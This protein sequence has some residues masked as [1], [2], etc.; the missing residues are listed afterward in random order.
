MQG[1]SAG[2]GCATSG[3]GVKASGNTWG[4][5]DVLTMEVTVRR[6]R[7]LARYRGEWSPPE[8]NILRR[9]DMD[10]GSIFGYRG[11]SDVASGETRALSSEEVLV[12]LEGGVGRGGG[13]D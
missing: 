13:S 8:T 11:S 7:E 5:G 6:T 10:G 3:S 1:L 12:R 2:K 9:T 4:A